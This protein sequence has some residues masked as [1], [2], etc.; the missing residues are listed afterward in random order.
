M[1]SEDEKLAK[2]R[3]DGARW[4][5][6]Y[7][8]R[9]TPERREEYFRIN[10]E[11]GAAR[12]ASETPEQREARL[13]RARARQKEKYDADPDAY[14]ERTRAWRTAN[15]EKNKEVQAKAH[16]KRKTEKPEAVQSVRSAWKARNAD[17]LN[18]YQNEYRRERYQTDPQFKLAVS[19]RNRL[20]KMIAKT[21]CGTV[22]AGR[23]IELLGCS[24]DELRA[25]LESQFQPGMSWDN[26]SVRGWHIDHKKP[27]ASFDLTDADQ[28]RQ[29]F[30]W[31]N[32]QPMWGA[33]NIA[34]G[35]RE[36]PLAA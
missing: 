34:K 12:R 19:L 33:E 29:C 27:C 14:R 31:S 8:A 26:H 28:Q 6:A 32:L 21:A 7:F 22:R 2:K 18:E 4:R 36:L 1:S 23:T 10:N 5:A 11:K 13:S 3:A 25:H 35:A 15:P 24:I 17:R 30:H 9:M 20:R 16:R